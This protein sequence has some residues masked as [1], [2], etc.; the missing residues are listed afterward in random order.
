MS[1]AIRA[2]AIASLIPVPLIA[3]AALLGG[4][5]VLAALLYMTLGA[6]ALDELL[7]GPPQEAG[8]ECGADDLSVVL[9]TLHFGLLALTVWAMAG[10]NSLGWLERFGLFFAAGLWFGEV[11]NA[12]AHELIHR[13]DKRLF[14]LG[15]WVYISLLFG[16]HT[17]AH[18][19]VHHRYAASPQDP[20]SARESESFYHF[21]PRAWAGSFIAGLEAETADLRRF[22]GNTRRNPYRAYVGG[23]LAM[24]VLAWLIAGFPGVLA[25]LLIAFYA[26]CQLMLSDYVQHYGL[27]RI[28]LPDGRLE[29]IGPAHSWNA[30]Q[31]FTA[32]LM[33]N[34]P[35]HSDHHAHPARAFPALELPGKQEA[36]RLP[37]SLP[38]MGALA[39][40]PRRW[41]R[42]MR[43]EL[44]SWRIARAE[45]T[46]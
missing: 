9:A 27:E 43:R 19:K 39:L 3:L 33:L 29:P 46:A 16:H 4:V 37:Y 8:T 14:E 32:R 36:P 21:L 24:L 28:R 45:Q 6:F 12:N 38:A 18:T 17:S 44:E 31:W 10:M 15:K 13:L 11:S 26:Q 7:Q 40:F 1:P 35:R 30:G 23:A 25:Y 41:K 2:F 20:N 22:S 34:A 5:W 42:V